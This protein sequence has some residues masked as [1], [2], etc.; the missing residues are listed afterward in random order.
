MG[1][2]GKLKFQSVTK[3]VDLT[4][5]QEPDGIRER[6]AEAY[7]QEYL[8]SHVKMRGVKVARAVVN[9]SGVFD[10]PNLWGDSPG[11]SAPHY[12]NLP[13]FCDV[14]IH[15]CTGKHTEVIWVWVPLA[16]NGRFLGIPG[17]G[18]RTALLND[19][20]WDALGRMASMPMSIRN[21]FACVC[22]DGGNREPEYFGWGVN[23]ET[24]EFDLELYH[25]WIDYSTH[26][27]TV[28]GK[29]VTEALAGEKIAYSYILG[30]SG[31]GRQVLAEAQKYPEDYDGYWCDS[32]CLSYNRMLPSLAWPA[33]V[34]NEYKNPMPPAKF[35]AFRA[36]AWEKA[37][38]REAYYNTQEIIEVDPYS[39]VG[40]ETEAGPITETDARVMELIWQGAQT[41]DGEFLWYGMRPGTEAWSGYGNYAGVT[42]TESGWVAEPFCLTVDLFRNWVVRDKNWDFSQCTIA[43]FERLFRK[44]MELFPDMDTENPDLRNL[45]DSGAKMILCHGIDDAAIYVDG[46]V[47][48][49]KKLMNLFG[50]KEKTKEVVRMLLVPGDAHGMHFTKNGAGPSHATAM[51]ALMDWVENGNA[52]EAIHGQRFDMATQTFAEEKDTPIY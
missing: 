43:E 46:T 38:G 44:T 31:G 6:C 27:M 47:A 21:G 36:A 33:V 48:Y 4:G 23:W 41:A 18:N 16:W 13:V 14:E 1:T 5:V 19:E 34:M 9:T 39:L 26:T 10:P 37:G 22:S 17:G 2:R 49:Y 29:A 11:M 12:E 35:E 20:S 51:L 40:Q 28:I 3:Y 8:N 7:I 15:H 32:P 25:N 30:G 24:K 52:P 45:R 42:K 50:S